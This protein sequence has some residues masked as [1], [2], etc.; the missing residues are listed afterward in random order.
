MVFWSFS[1]MVFGDDLFPETVS[2]MVVLQFSLL[3]P[4]G[5]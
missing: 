3:A 4:F 2:E 1:S 5:H